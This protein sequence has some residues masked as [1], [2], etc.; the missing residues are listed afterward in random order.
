MWSPEGNQEWTY[1]ENLAKIC[2]KNSAHCQAQWLTPIIL[3]TQEA[4]I[5][6]IAFRSQPGQT[7]HETLSQKKTKVADPEFKPH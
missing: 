6:R 3:V 2:F 4:E 7:I 1:D 5:G